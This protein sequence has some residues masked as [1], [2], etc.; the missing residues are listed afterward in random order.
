MSKTLAKSKTDPSGDADLRYGSEVQLLTDWVDTTNFVVIGGRGT[1][2]STVVI[3]RRSHSCVLAMP[4]APLAIVADTYTNL[5]NNIMPAVQN[6]WKLQGW[7]EG[8][9]YVKGCK[10]PQQWRKRCS[11]IVDDYRHVYSFW[12]GTVLF[13]GSLD[14]PSLLAGKSV[15]H[16]FFDEAKYASDTRAARVLPILR[17]DAITYGHSH[18]Y[19]GVTITT[20]MP[21]VTEGEFD[22]FFR[23]ASEMDPERIVRIVQAAGV[24]NDLERQLASMQSQDRRGRLERK[25]QYYDNALLKLRKGQ[26]FFTNLSSFAN[27]DVLT[28]DYARRLYGGALEP[29]EF[30][31]SVMGMRPGLKKSARFYVLFSDTHKYTDGTLSREAAF[32]CSELL[33]LHPDEPLDG[34]MDFGN[35]LSLVIAQADGQYYRVHKNLYELPPGWFRELA[36]RF[37]D[38]FAPHRCKTLNLYYDRAGNNFQSQGEDSAGKFKAAIEKDGQ[39]RRTGWTVNLMSRHQ[40]IIRQDAEFSFMMELMRGENKSL[41]LLRVDALNCAEMVS[42][43]EGARQTMKYRGA[44]KIV[45]KVKKTEKLELRKLPRLSTNFSDAFKYLM[46]RRAWVAAVKAAPANGSRA[47]AAADRWLQERYSR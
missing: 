12:N 7:M 27:I 1:S 10:P 11:V 47:D 38:F 33:T 40:A 18:L 5:V 23:Y 39:G 44:Q 43:I 28:V 41:P 9:H 3:A 2:K 46:M 19:G 13:L 22:W 31:K 17:G 34:G 20:D 4:G 35:M 21:D 30:F 37:L 45:A 15:A 24:R 25:L 29:Q 32:S 42:S 6:G 36:D 14:S 8:V 26:T 16:L